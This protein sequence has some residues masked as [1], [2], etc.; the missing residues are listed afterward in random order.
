[1]QPRRTVLVLT[2]ER[3][4]AASMVLST[5]DGT[6]DVARGT[7]GFARAGDG[8]VLLAGDRVRTSE[9]GHAIVTFFD[10]STV[11]IEPGGSW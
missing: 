5:L 10:G 11:E 9:Q 2:Q 4:V 1:M 8:Q 3:A 7:G 6:A